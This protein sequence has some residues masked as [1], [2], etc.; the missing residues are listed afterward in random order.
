MESL[1]CV[2]EGM[3]SLDRAEEVRVGVD[4]VEEV[5]VGV[6][7]LAE[8]GYQDLQI[9]VHEEASEEAWDL[10]MDIERNNLTV[11]V[12]RDLGSEEVQI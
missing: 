4:H 9:E 3:E 7:D 11:V 2:E 1:D 10:Q 8:V 12:Q 5:R 6:V